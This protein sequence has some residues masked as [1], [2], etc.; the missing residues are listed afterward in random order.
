LTIERPTKLV[1]EQER[2]PKDI[3]YALLAVLE[4]EINL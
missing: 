3:E 2:L 1:G 4:K